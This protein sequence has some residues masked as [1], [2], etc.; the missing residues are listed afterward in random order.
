MKVWR[1]AS[2]PAINFYPE[3]NFEIFQKNLNCSQ[4]ENRKK[5]EYFDPAIKQQL[6]QTGGDMLVKYGNEK[7]DIWESSAPGLVS[8]LHFAH[9]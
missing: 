7:D 3:K 6:K 4:E 9:R 5:K 8:S 2:I 1:T